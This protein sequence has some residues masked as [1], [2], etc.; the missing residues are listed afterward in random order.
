MQFVNRK[1]SLFLMDGEL[2]AVG[3]QCAQ[4]KMKRPWRGTC[5]RPWYVGLGFR[6]HVKPIGMYPCRTA[7]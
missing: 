1:V 3:Q 4:H 7:F 6:D 5:N 2:E